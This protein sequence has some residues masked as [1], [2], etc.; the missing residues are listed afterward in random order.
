VQPD[1]VEIHPSSITLCFILSFRLLG[2]PLFGP[3]AFVLYS[4]PLDEDHRMSVRE[5]PSLQAA[6]PLVRGLSG[7]HCIDAIFVNTPLRDYGKRGR[8]NDFTL[9]VLGLG[10]IATVAAQHGLNVGVLDGESLGLGFEEI[11]REINERAPRWVGLNLLAPTYR[12]SVEILRILDSNIKVVLGGHQAKA[13]PEYI[14]R[15]QRIPR[16]DA[17]IVGEAEHRVTELLRGSTPIDELPQVH[18]RSGATI[19]SSPS[20]HV[21]PRLLS[22][23]LNELPF[24]DRKFLTNDPYREDGLLEASIVGSRG[25]PFD[26]SFCGAAVSANPGVSVRTRHPAN[27]LDE[28]FSLKAMHGVSAVRFVDDL[29]LANKKFIEE[30]LSAFI[31]E[32]IHLRWDATARINVL[33]KLPSD[34]LELLKRSGCREVALGIETASDRLLQ[35]VD[36]KI[37]LAQIETAVIRTCECGINVKGYFIFGLPTERR[38]EHYKTISLIE[39]LWD[40]TE[41]LPGRFRCSVF[42]YRPYPGTPDWRRLV[43]TRYSVSELLTYDEVDLTEGGTDPLLLD[44]DEFNFT[45]GLTFGEVPLPEL[46]RNLSKIMRQQKARLLHYEDSLSRTL[47]KAQPTKEDT[48]SSVLA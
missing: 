45:T 31:S 30:C 13:L 48:F 37:T 29:F 14:L 34:T 39:R 32:K 15:D 2:V 38:D 19:C 43:P 40:K 20:S 10:Y 23:D 47:S 18:W 26:C 35:Y 25:C 24:V 4:F 36:K 27:I 28:L 8:Y 44:R 17:L 16:I 21:N 7:R 11:A 5:M 33:A 6:S 22:P 1:S 9:P 3:K 42:E 41:K 46:R 12:H